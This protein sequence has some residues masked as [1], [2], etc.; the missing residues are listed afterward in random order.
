MVN[1]ALGWDFGHE[2]I[3]VIKDKPACIF[4]AISHSQIIPT[5]F[6]SINKKKVRMCLFT[7]P[8]FRPCISQN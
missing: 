1:S 2:P 4:C 7:M 8:A 3:A 6:H 5:S